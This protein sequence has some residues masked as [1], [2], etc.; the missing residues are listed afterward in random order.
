MAD[1]G[2]VQNPGGGRRVNHKKTTTKNKSA[3]TVQITAEQII[4]EAVANQ[5]EPFKPPKQQIM[6]KEE[7]EA[8]KLTKRK[9]FEDRIRMHRGVAIHW[10][11]YAKWEEKQKEVDRARSIYERALDDDYRNAI[12]YIKY[13]EMEMR[14]KNVNHARNVLDRGISLLPRMDQLWYKYVFMEEVLGNYPA[15]RQLYE[16]WME[17]KPPESCWNAYINFELKFNETERA[18][19][20]YRRLVEVHVTPAN[21]IRW[22]KFEE[23]MGETLNAR[24]VYEGA[25]EY[26]GEDANNIE[27]FTE[28]AKFEENAK[29]VCCSFFFLLIEYYNFLYILKV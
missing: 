12:V 5:E 23:K 9:E 11:T 14:N 13:A 16:R 18:R 29:E 10:L 15:I 7:Y 17:W 27:L 28:F 1:L 8:Y 25:I 3:N 6:D 20:V 4:R 24:A 21:W 26:L 22:A 19:Q 2:D